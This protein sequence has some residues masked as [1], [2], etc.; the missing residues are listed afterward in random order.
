MSYAA[1]PGSL[2]GSAQGW[3]KNCR[4][5]H[6]AGPRRWSRHAHGVP[7]HAPRHHRAEPRPPEAT[8]AYRRAGEESQ[9]TA[10]VGSFRSAQDASTV[11]IHPTISPHSVS[12]DGRTDLAPLDWTELCDDL[13]NRRGRQELR[14]RPLSMQNVIKCI[15]RGSACLA[16]SCGWGC[17]AACK[18]LY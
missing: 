8:G 17:V 2:S 13:S 7:G 16:G 4:R 18:L 3:G 11:L 10:R 14:T 5:G 15:G 1:R 9:G 12:E 6:A